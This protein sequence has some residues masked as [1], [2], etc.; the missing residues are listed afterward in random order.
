[1]YG[2]TDDTVA[3]LAEMPQIIGLKDA[4]SDVTR[5]LRLRSLLGS[6]LRLLSGDDATAPAFL[7]MG[8]DGCISVTS[9]VAPAL[10]RSMYLAL[11]QGQPAQAQRLVTAAATLTA[12]LFS[13]S[14]PAPVKYALSLMN[15]M[16]PRVRLPLVELSVESKAR[17]EKALA[18]TSAR[19]P[20]YLIANVVGRDRNIVLSVDSARTR[21]KL[22]VAS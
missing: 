5:P 2:L 4:T 3:R 10:C 13:E 14:N 22:V 12:A 9:N 19:H 17:V 11:R 7:A 20:G 18:D 16:S 21:P 8:G 1:V 15:I 6:E